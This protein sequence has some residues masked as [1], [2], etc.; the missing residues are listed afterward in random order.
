MS[1]R[2]ALAF[3]PTAQEPVRTTCPYCGVGCGV[4][5]RRSDSAELRGS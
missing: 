1:E 2:P 4:I 5:A 3:A